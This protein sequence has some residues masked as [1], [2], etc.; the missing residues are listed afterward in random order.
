[1]ADLI[2]LS[3]KKRDVTGKKVKALRRDGIVPATVYQKG[4]ESVSVTVDYQEFVKAYSAAGLGQPVELTVDGEK[5]L[6]MIKEVDLDPAKHTVMHVAFHAVRANRAV[7][8]EIPVE[9]EGD[10]PAEVK[11]NFTVRPNDTV[12]VKAIPANLPEKIVVSGE[13]LQEA[14]DTITV[15]DV[16]AMSDVEILSEPE[17]QLFVAEEPRVVEEE[18]EEEAVDAADVPSDN[19]GESSEEASEE[20]AE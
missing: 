1:M 5:R 10:I 2:A 13:L 8:A 17:T 14:G 11:G 15:A 19:G 7:E 12:L 9:I 4:K 20:S 6:T 16:K 3:A 18:P